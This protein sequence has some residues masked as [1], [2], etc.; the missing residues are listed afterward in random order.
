MEE[1]VLQ[2]SASK[3]KLVHQCFGKY[4]Y[5]YII[6]IPF[7]QTIWP[8]TIFGTI[9]HKIL[10]EV[11]LNKKDKMSDEDILEKVNNRFEA[12]FLHQ[13]DNIKKDKNKVFKKSMD[14]REDTFLKKG[15]K[16]ALSISKFVLKY[17]GHEIYDINPELIMES[18]WEYTPNVFIKGV[19]DLPLHTSKI[20][21]KIVDF[22]TT[23]DSNNFYFIYWPT[24][25]QSLVY[26]YLCYKK[27]GTFATGFEYLVCNHEEKNMFINSKYFI[28]LPKTKEEIKK[29]F[30][31]L[32]IEI[33]NI[34][35]M[36]KKPKEEYWNPTVD[37]CG[38]CEFSRWCKLSKSI[39]KDNQYEKEY[40]KG[41]EIK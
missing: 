20:E 10:E 18:N 33:N 23:K 5:R 4:Y 14:Y 13:L 9:I 2:L 6:K 11:M 15:E 24:D 7:I 3:I 12:E 17:Y 22:K 19:A 27:F 32:D 1:E 41:N 38:F 31:P 28:E 21:Y 35:D 8:G 25:I 26:L 36:I 40:I 37:N 16:T 34:I 39:R 29:F 30:E